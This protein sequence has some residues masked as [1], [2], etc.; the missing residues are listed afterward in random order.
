[1]SK[2]KS[3]YETEEFKK[4]QKEWYKKAKETGFD[5]IESGQQQNYDTIAK[6]EFVPDHARVVYFE[7]CLA[8]Y[9][10]TK[11][12]DKTDDF[13]FYQHCMGTSNHQIVNM[14][15]AAELKPLK[16][17]AIAERVIKILKIA[18]IEPILF[19]F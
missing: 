17:S 19:T 18:D 11:W 5:D 1:M 13:I 10:K 12:E 3:V 4:L 9:H 8:F 6:Q 16:K 7:R 15:V 14:L 2:K